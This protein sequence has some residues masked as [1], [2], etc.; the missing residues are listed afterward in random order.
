MKILYLVIG[1]MSLIIGVVGIILPILPTTPFL[2]LTAYLFTKSS[3][4]FH[5]WFVNTK[6]YSKYLDD[7]IENKEMTRKYKWTL[8]ISVDIMLL[9]SFITI[10]SLYLKVLLVTLFIFKHYYFYKYINI[11]KV[12]Q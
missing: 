1:F 12:I 7:F 6:L 3:E 2:I 10:E 11:K 5:N 4:R 8:L 9:L